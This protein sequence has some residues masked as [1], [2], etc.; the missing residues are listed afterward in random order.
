MLDGGE[1]WRRL[2]GDIFLPDQGETGLG[3]FERAV[4]STVAAKPA[5]RKIRDG[6]SRGL[7]EADPAGTLADRALRKGL[8]NR[9]E[10][11]YVVAA[12][13]AIGAAIEVD[14]YSVE[15]YAGLKG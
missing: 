13:G 7:I 3:S 15:S 12:A 10:S 14:V 8:I 4:C 6:V 11:D 9:E 1:V 2:T 5:A